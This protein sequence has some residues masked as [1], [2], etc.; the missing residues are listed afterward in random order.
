MC[1]EAEPDAAFSEARFEDAQE[2]LAPFNIVIGKLLA[3]AVHV[4]VARVEG[5]AGVFGETLGS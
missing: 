1:V 4:V 2:T 3:I 5:E